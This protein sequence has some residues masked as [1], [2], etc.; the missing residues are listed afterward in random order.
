MKLKSIIISCVL[1]FLCSVNTFSQDL[2][3]GYPSPVT[4]DGW[5]NET[6]KSTSINTYESM[7]SFSGGGSTSL[8]LISSDIFGR[9]LNYQQFASENI[10]LLVSD[11]DNP[12]NTDESE[13]GLLD[14]DAPVGGSEMIAFLVLATAIFFLVKKRRSGVVL[15]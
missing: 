6:E 7:T 4:R 9:T 8:H 15:K 2:F 10:G 1:A 5:L 3:S 12:N 13:I 11:A 14:E